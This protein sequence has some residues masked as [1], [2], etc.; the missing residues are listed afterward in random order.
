MVSKPG[1]K[2]A[3]VA[4]PKGQ[5]F[6]DKS[7]P[8][9]IRLSNINAAKGNFTLL[10]VLMSLDMNEYLFFLVKFTFFTQFS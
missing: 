9:D 1:T 3:A 6:K 5:A 8:A 4:K 2:A 10:K 7:K